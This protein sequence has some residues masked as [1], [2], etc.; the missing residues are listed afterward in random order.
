MLLDQRPSL[1][2]R[3]TKHSEARHYLDEEQ[4]IK[5]FLS[6]T[7]EKANEILLQAHVGA[8]IKGTIKDL[9]LV[10]DNFEKLI[11]SMTGQSSDSRIL[12]KKLEQA[13]VESKA[14]EVNIESLKKVLLLIVDEVK[15]INVE[16][17]QV[18][19]RHEA[20]Q[21]Q[22]VDALSATRIKSA[23]QKIIDVIVGQ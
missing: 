9:L 19:K 4:R 12:K 23:T 2:S 1:F 15:K 6:Q 21:S 11:Q 20:K 16:A 14:F 3:S 5:L 7:K 8:D 18:I 10:G 22:A 17:A 13:K